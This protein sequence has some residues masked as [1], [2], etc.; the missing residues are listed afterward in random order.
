MPNDAP[1]DDDAEF[2]WIGGKLVALPGWERDEGR[3]LIRLLTCG[4]N[5]PIAILKKWTDDECRVA[6][7]WALSAHYS[8]SDN[9]VCV[10]PEPDHVKRYHGAEA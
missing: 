7:I 6:D 10:P 4:V 1:D 5:I 3:T 9:L 8:A 2:E